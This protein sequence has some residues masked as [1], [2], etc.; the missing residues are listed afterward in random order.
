MFRPLLRWAYLCLCFA[1]MAWASLGWAQ[2]ANP[3]PGA[4]GVPLKP[5]PE[6]PAARATAPPP[7]KPPDTSV[8][9]L[10]EAVITI[11]GLCDTPVGEKTAPA[12]CKTVI[13]RA[14]F[15]KIVDALQPNLP[16]PQQ[17]QL[18]GSYANVLMLA[19]EAHRLG[20]DKGPEFEERL[21]LAKLQAM[22]QLAAK[23]ARS[24]ATEISD[25]EIADYYQSHLSQYDQASA[26]QL[27]VPLMKQTA[28]KGAAATPPKSMAESAAEMR[29]E[30]EALRA[31]AAAGEDFEK[32]QGEA[33]QFAGLKTPP[34][35]VHIP[36]L[37]RSSLSAARASVMDLKVGEVSPV[38]VDPTGFFVYKIEK[39]ESV[40][41]EQVRSEIEGQLKVEKQR[42][43][44]QALEH[45]GTPK[46]DEK[47]F[48][49]A[50]PAPGRVPGGPPAAGRPAP[51]TPKT[52]AA[53]PVP[54]PA[55]SSSS[56]P[57]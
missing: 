24:Q 10:D 15:E 43:A 4:P 8:V 5:A 2:A 35:D 6:G 27:F 28:A 51:L 19:H 22:A 26:E 12:D 37:R 14:Q 32:L 53:K 16:L 33:N 36:N 49:E 1:V 13:T 25:K 41:L 11:E 45:L 29:K 47:Y 55:N 20:L 42:A 23:N 21:Q 38:I 34:R 18:A 40:P 50:A 46:L 7:T 39:K 48:G 56:G 44:M 17:R 3:T 31:R 57:K 52:P 30:A 9:P 54:A